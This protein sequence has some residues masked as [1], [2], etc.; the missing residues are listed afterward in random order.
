M[1]QKNVLIAV[2]ACYDVCADPSQ[3]GAGT[4]LYNGDFNPQYNQSAPQ[5]GLYQDLR[6]QLPEGWPAGESVLQVAHQFTV[7]VRAILV[8][9]LWCDT[10]SV[11][12]GERGASL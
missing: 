12:A 1:S 11:Y 2:T 3:W 6:V 10:D 7:G 5:K 9:L 4:I 8:S